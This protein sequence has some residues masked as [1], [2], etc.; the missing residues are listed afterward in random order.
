MNKERQSYHGL[1]SLKIEDL[2]REM[3]FSNDLEFSGR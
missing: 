2:G 3:P 1:Q